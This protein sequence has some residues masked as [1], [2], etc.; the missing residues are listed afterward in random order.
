MKLFSAIIK[1]HFGGNCELHPL[2]LWHEVNCCWNHF[3]FH[4]NLQHFWL[5]VHSFWVLKYSLQRWLVF[6]D[7]G[8][9][10]HFCRM[11]LI[12]DCFWSINSPARAQ[13]LILLKPNLL[14]V[15]F[16]VHPTSYKSW[17]GGDKATANPLSHSKFVVFSK[18]TSD[19]SWG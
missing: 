15:C 14:G 2:S 1:V 11:N 19:G 10:I 13:S 16:K 9:T 6:S 17:E 7:C 12:C 4:Y 3:W 18:P 5:Q 8:I